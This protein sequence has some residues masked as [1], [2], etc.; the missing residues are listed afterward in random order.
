MT[1]ST[2]RWLGERE[3]TMWRSLVQTLARLPTAL[4]DQLQ[5]DSQLSFVEYYVLAALSEAPEGVV[6]MS[7]LAVLTNAEQS[8]LSHLMKRL[9]ARGLARRERDPDN[10]RFINAHLTQAGLDCIRKA[11]PGHVEQVRR[12][13]FDVLTEQDVE[14][15]TRICD[16]IND[17]L[18]P[19]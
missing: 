2:P 18:G 10:G 15:L 19:Y 1:D 17:R 12:L 14:S 7:T 11:A 8:R 13:V 5:D 16:R 6:R 3:L 9:E 4:D